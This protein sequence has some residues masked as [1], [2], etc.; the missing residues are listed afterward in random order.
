MFKKSKNKAK[1]VRIDTLIGQNTQI[2]GDLNFSGGLRI[3]GKVVGNISTT[4]SAGAVLTLG[5]QGSIEGEIRVPN[6]IINGSI[7]G[8]VYVSDH[9]ELADKAKVNG[10]LYYRLLEMAIG[11]EV[12]GQLIRMSTDNDNIL[13]LDHEVIDQQDTFQLEQKANLD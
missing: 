1:A 4:D 2:R 3:D 12:N 10:N 6:L 5:E 7:N 9:V 11:S 13:N 8:N